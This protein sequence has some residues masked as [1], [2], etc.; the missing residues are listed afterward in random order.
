MKRDFSQE[1]YYFLL[2]KEMHELGL[3]SDEKYK[4]AIADIWKI[5]SAI[6]KQFSFYG[7]RSDFLTEDNLDK[8]GEEFK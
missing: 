2:M 7:L 5:E 4:K 3:I 6:L 8:E 1:L